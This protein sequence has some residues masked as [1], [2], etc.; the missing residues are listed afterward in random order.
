M[1]DNLNQIR[2]IDLERK[3][4][5]SIILNN[6][7]WYGVVES[8]IGEDCFYDN[9]HKKLFKIIEN[10]SKENEII[11]LTTVSNYLVKHNL[12]NA[13]T[14][15]YLAGIVNSIPST[16]GFQSYLKELKQY[17]EKRDIMSLMLYIQ[18]NFNMENEELKDNI[19]HKVL[20]L[21]TAD[22][23]DNGEIREGIK[24]L[25]NDMEYRL[26]NDNLDKIG[27]LITGLKRLDLTIDGFCKSEFITIVARSGIGKTTFATS[28]ILNMI[29][30]NYK[31][32]MFSME[33]PQEQIIK[34]MAFNY[35]NIDAQKYKTGELDNDEVSKIIRF[36]DWLEERENIHIY[37]ESNFNNMVAKAKA[38]HLKNGLDIIFVDYLN[39]IQGVK[40]STRDIEL[41]TITSTLKDLALQENVCVVAL[42]Q[43]NRQVDKQHDKRL[44]LADIK[45]S[46]SIENNSD[47][48]IALYRNKNLDNPNY[49]EKLYSDGK[50]DYNKV[51]ADYNPGCME[52]EVL[53][54]RHGECKT[55]GCRW[56]GEFSRV[57]NWSDIEMKNYK[58]IKN[59]AYPF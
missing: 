17:K 21:T 5:G 54:N 32:A 4:I 29:R 2:N 57:K 3:I 8:N 52:V 24:N 9:K 37:H 26:T 48:I 44:T 51:N 55:I 50:L 23:K 39:K 33:M 18:N 15:T 42:T 10:L 6:D 13:I 56:E 25:K 34:K 53:K 35:C 27:G 45:E 1:K 11:D 43:A 36:T 7:L 38:E 14:I 28:I 49:R 47:K 22:K 31:I 16:A 59:G 41:N 19:T 12:N 20:A 30:N 46:S 58:E 40:G